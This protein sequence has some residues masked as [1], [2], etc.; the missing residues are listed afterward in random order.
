M[1]F[2]SNELKAQIARKGYTQE[3]LAKEIGIAPETLS[4]KMKLGV[5]KT[6]EVMKIMKILDIEDPSP[7]FFAK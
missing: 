1:S 5:F 3:R 6:D 4:R 2:S 7:I